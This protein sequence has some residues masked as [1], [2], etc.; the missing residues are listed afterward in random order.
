MFL[1]TPSDNIKNRFWR[2]NSNT[3]H[4][5]SSRSSYSTPRRS[6]VS[7]FHKSTPQTSPKHGRINTAPLVT[8]RHKDMEMNESQEIIRRALL[9]DTPQYIKRTSSNLH[10]V[11]PTLEEIRHSFKSFPL[12]IYIIL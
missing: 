1:K 4:A 8:P 5:P 10:F 3:P 11:D 7:I 12:Y 2:N 6:R 9:L